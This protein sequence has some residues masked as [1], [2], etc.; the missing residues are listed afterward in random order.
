[1]FPST[2]RPSPAAVSRPSARRRSQTAS[3]YTRDSYSQSGPR[4]STDDIIHLTRPATSLSSTVNTPS[5]SRSR[6][7]SYIGTSESNQVVCAVAEA[8]GVSPSVGIAHFNVSTG[9]AVLSQICDTQFYIKTATKLQIVEPSRV[10]VVSTSCP[11]QP[12]S[13]LYNV[14]EE[15]LPGVRLV[16]LDRKYWN[17]TAGLEYIQSLAFREDVEAIK[18]A[19]EGNFYATCSFSAVCN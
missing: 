17:E 2:P 15:Q 3:S 7:T 4:S 18:V 8:R 13:T 16:P 11:P 5:R 9:E 12:K 1:M 6:A 10:L 14:I 19:I